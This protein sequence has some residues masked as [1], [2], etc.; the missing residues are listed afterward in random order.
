MKI[1]ND[2]IKALLHFEALPKE[3]QLKFIQY[4]TEIYNK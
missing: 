4:I 3:L 1:N 2:Y